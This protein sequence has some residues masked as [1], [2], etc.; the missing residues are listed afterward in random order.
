MN[1]AIGAKE[2][3]LLS[4]YLDNELPAADADTVT[5]R[6]AKEPL[7]AERLSQLRQATDDARKQFRAIDDIPLPQAVVDLLQRDSRSAANEAAAGNVVQ[8]APRG[9]RTFLQVPVALAAGIALLAG[10]FV[11]NQ[12]QRT[13]DT[14]PDSL[15]ARD[16]AMDSSLHKLLETG[17]GADS[18]SLATDTSAQLRITFLDVSGDYCRQFA[19]AGPGTNAQALACRRGGQ[20]RMEA[21][22]LAAPAAAAYQS[23]SAD[24]SS[25]VEAAIDALI[26]PGE[27]VNESTEKRLISNGWN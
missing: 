24:P 23:A 26:G 14:T 22:S 7:L 11:A 9:I 2:D 3:E 1:D 16:I 12:V 5:L 10:F 6:I 20:W 21:V 8:L 17:S 19:I 4:A 13:S 15:F 18:T 27:P 25:A